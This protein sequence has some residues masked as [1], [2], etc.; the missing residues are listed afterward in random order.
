MTD[1]DLIIEFEAIMA[2]AGEKL[3]ICPC[4]METHAETCP[5]CGCKLSGDTL[6][7]AIRQK[8]EAGEDVDLDQLDPRLAKKPGADTFIPVLPGE[9]PP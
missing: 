3:K 2:F 6:A 9:L 8:V 5:V 4:G 7:D 1:D